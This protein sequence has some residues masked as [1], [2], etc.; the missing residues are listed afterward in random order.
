[1]TFDDVNE[2]TIAYDDPVRVMD[3]A[4]EAATTTPKL[5]RRDINISNGGHSRRNS[6]GLAAALSIAYRTI[7]LRGLTSTG[8]W[9]SMSLTTKRG[10]MTSRKP[11]RRLRA[12]PTAVG[13]VR[14][15]YTFVGPCP[16]RTRF[17]QLLFWVVLD[18]FFW[19]LVFSS[20]ANPSETLL[21]L[22]VF[23]LGKSIGQNTTL[24]GILSEVY[25][26]DELLLT[27]KAA[28]DI[29]VTRCDMYINPDGVSCLLD[30]NTRAEIENI[31]NKWSRE[32]KRVI[33]LAHKFLSSS[34]TVAS[35]SSWRFERETMEHASS[36]LSIIDPPLEEIPI[37]TLRKAGIRIFM[38]TG[39][40]V[41]TAEAITREC[42]IILNPSDR[43]H[44][45]SYLRRDGAAE[46]SR[47]GPITSI[48]ISGSGL[49]ML[50]DN[51]WELLCQY[52]EIELQA[53]ASI[54]GMTG[55]GVND[56][57]SL[58]AADIGVAL[59]SGSD[60]AIEA[61]DMVRLDKFDGIVEAVEYG[62]VVFDNL[63]K[64][65]AYLLPAGS[66]AELWPVVTNVGLVFL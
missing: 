26:G 65:V 58:K 33:L 19:L 9:A 10:A 44:D 1:M 13:Q 53:E 24:T 28:P 34:S 11:V 40:F 57:P 49:T 42:R 27:I 8:P 17:V 45:M 7:T 46:K 35:P 54:V 5:R 50:S 61:S 22:S 21:L 41:L 36:G 39:D 4:E 6:I 60:I 55:D 52:D 47:P 29:L 25:T 64:T 16:P 32:G 51:E 63:K 23:S 15:E 12:R 18:R 66:Y 43:V 2:Q 31:K 48:V 56:A 62:R 30:S 38:V 59:G 3:A 20:F 37:S 14:K